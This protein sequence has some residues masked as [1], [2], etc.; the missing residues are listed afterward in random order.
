[1]TTQGFVSTLSV[2]DDQLYMINRRT[3]GGV[4]S[5]FIERWSFDMLMDNSIAIANN[6][7][8]TV[9]GFRAS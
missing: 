9:S 8:T 5:N 7:S 2:V 3:L 6:N 4:T 1:M